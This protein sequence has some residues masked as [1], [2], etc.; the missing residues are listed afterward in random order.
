MSLALF[1]RSVDRLLNGLAFVEKIFGMFAMGFI[2]V[3]NIYGIGSRYLFDLPVLFV[4]E[5]TILG[6][7]WLFFIGMGLVFKVHSDITVEFFMRLMP[8]RFGLVNNLV[9]ELLILFFTLVLAWQTVLLIPFTRGASS[10]LSFALGLPDEIYFY[11]IGLGA[12]SIFLAVGHSFIKD[13]IR[14]RSDWNTG[15]PVEEPT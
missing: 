3:I 13:L 12:V 9:I 6:A 11:P 1:E 7:V 2:I 5:L 14:F 15:A 10:F 4:H 8:R